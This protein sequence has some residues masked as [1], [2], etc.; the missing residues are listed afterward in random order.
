LAL[1][2][3]ALVP[4]L[5]LAV[6]L[7]APTPDAGARS[8]SDRPRTLRV[9]SSA[10][11]PGDGSPARPYRTISRAVR[12]AQ[13]GDTVLVAAGRYA[14]YVTSARPGRPGAPIRIVGRPGAHLVGPRGIAR[15]RLVQLLHDHVTVE[16]LELSG[17]NIL[18]WVRGASGVRLL[19]NQIHDAGGECVRLKDHAQGN[20]VAGN[21][22]ARCGRVRFNLAKGSKNGEGVY[23]GTAPEQAGGRPDRS[24]GNRVLRNRIA[25]SAECVEVKEAARRNRVEH[26]RCAGS[27]DPDGA[28]FSSRGDRTVFRAN[29]S[30]RHAGAGIRLGGDRPTQGLHNA[31]VGNLL[32]DNAGYGLKLMR[33]PQGRIAANTFA[34]NRR[35]R[36]NHWP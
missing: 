30:T 29:I 15:G 25:P 21:R 19:G 28:G 33:S 14:E 7:A 4:L 6:T 12:A 36:T 24:D 27:D 2:R 22:I 20:L 5:A 1:R 23:I 26:N 9:A 11:A 13:A 16:S 10:R 31:V 34:R 17:A 35:G 3:A 8:R 18:V 32:A